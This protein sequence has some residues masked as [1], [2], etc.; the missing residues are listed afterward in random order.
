MDTTTSVVLT[1]LVVFTGQWAEDDEG[2]SITLVVGAM[3][4]AVFLAALSS[5]N[6]RLASQFALL[7]LV[8]ALLRYVIPIT[9]KLGYSSED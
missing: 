1:G 6:D 7:I 8:G 9:R 3:V 4:L 5:S 2:P